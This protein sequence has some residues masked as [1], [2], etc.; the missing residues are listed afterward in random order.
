MTTTS[1][2]DART[3]STPAAAIR[4]RLDG[5]RPEAAL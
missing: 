4:V 2:T 1:T 5:F 3:H